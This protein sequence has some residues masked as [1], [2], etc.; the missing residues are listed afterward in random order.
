M[1]SVCQKLRLQDG[2][3]HRLFH[4]LGG[5]GRER[6]SFMRMLRMLRMLATRCEAVV[7]HALKTRNVELVSFTS[8]VSSDPD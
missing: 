3:L 1:S 8:S 2:R 5:G 4:L 6:G 7:D